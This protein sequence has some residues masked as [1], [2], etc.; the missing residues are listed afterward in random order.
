MVCQEGFAETALTRLG[1]CEVPTL[2]GRY[3]EEPPAIGPSGR[4]FVIHK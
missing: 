1:R 2:L 4:H 3:I